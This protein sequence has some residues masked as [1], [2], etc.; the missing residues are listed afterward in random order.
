MSCNTCR[1]IQRYDNRRLHSA[2]GCLSPPASRR[3]RLAPV[4]RVPRNWSLQGAR[5][6]LVNLMVQ[7]IA[8]I[9]IIFIYSL[10]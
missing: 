2:L 6:T 5:G 9:G 3:S 8:E 1:F 4:N 10:H 7:S